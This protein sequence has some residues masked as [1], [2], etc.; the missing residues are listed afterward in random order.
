MRVAESSLIRSCLLGGLLAAVT[1]GLAWAQQAGDTVQTD[2]SGVAVYRLD[3]IEVTATRTS[4]AVFRTP[5]AVSV[6]GQRLLETTPATGISEALKTLPGLDVT[7][8][9]MQQQRPVIRGLRGQRILL[10]QDGV[11][12]NNSRRQQDFGEVPSLIDLGQIDRV[13]VVRGPSS[14]LYGSDA[15]GG[16]INVITARPPRQDL[17]GV[18]SYEYSS[19]FEGSTLRGRLGGGSDRVAYEFGGHWRSGDAYAAPEGSFGDISL[20]TDTEVLGTG[21]EDWSMGGRVLAT[22]ADGHDLSFQVDAY[23]AD[24]AGFGLIEPANFAPSMPRIDIGYPTQSFARFTVGYDGQLDTGLADRLSVRAYTQD[25]ERELVFDFVQGFGPTAPPGAELSILNTNTTDLRTLGFRAE[26]RKLAGPLL[27][28]YGID[29]FRDRSDNS[30]RSVTRVTGFGPPSIEESSQPRVPNATYRS[31]GAFTQAEFEEG[32]LTLIGGARVQSARAETRVTPGVD[33]LGTDQ[34]A[35]AVVGAL[36]AMVALSNSWTVIGSVG[37]GF[38][39]PNLV[40]WFFE[41]PVPEARA[42]QLRA[43]DLEPETSLSFDL[44][45]RFRSGRISAEAFVFQN[46]LTNGI[47]SEATG[48]T[49]QGL[50]AFKS[51]NLDELRY[52]G[53]EVSVAARLGAGLTADASYS[54]LSSEDVVQPDNPTGES[55]ANRWLGGLHWADADGRLWAEWGVRHNAEQKD[56]NLGNNPLGA[57]LPAFTVQHARAGIRPTEGRLLGTGLTVGIENITDVLYAEFANASFFRP[58]PG[59]RLVMRAEVVF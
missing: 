12:L 21:I 33:L 6:V 48:D 45:T 42:Y 28:T 18:L 54:H 3:P 55:F 25:N 14:V 46:T 58:E 37:R 36:N 59:R 5:A 2:T 43:T 26:A 30:D 57:V 53:A 1:P 19:A 52:R 38:R 4:R 41:G 8:V 27:F 17:G 32:R 13:E 51:L 16:V 9:G 22:A 34:S 20:A 47:R 23:R 44:G 40:E 35:T 10:L 50:A 39:A 11:R 49:I 31:L 15:I 29:G 24:D 7:G 56:V